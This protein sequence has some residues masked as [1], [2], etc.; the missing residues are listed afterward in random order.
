VKYCK[1]P[2]IN[3]LVA[4]LVRDGWQFRRGG[5]HG[6]LCTPQGTRTLTVPLSPSDHRAWLNFRRDVRHAQRSIALQ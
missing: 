5:R 3:T 4:Q 6:K 2:E 1:A